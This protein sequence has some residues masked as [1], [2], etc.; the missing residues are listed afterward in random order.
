MEE[1][2]EVK[3][4]NKN[5][6]KKKIVGLI[7]FMIGCVVLIAGIVAGI[8]RLVSTPGAR[9]AEYLVETKTWMLENEPGVV[10]Q[11]SEIGKGTLTSN[12]H[13]NDYDFLWAIEGDVI[14]IETNWL[15]TI[16]NEYTYE[17]NQNDGVLVLTNGDEEIKFV[18]VVIEEPTTEE[19]N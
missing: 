18:K 8:I 7:V 19:T 12:N 11:F 9:D 3:K 14:K 5:K 15:Y 10:W 6:D 1:K 2:V 4:E 13:V 16:N 17:L